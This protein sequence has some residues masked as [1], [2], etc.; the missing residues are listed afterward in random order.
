MGD[1]L[2]HYQQAEFL[3]AKAVE[4]GNT[5]EDYMAFCA[6]AQVHATLACVLHMENFEA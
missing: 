6:M 5:N 2:Y 4:P 1:W 3:L